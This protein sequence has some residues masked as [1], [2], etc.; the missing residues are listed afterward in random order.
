M[1]A[2]E[3]LELLERERYGDLAALEREAFTPRGRPPRPRKPVR[4]PF[5]APPPISREQGLANRRRLLEALVGT[6]YEPDPRPAAS[7]APPSRRTA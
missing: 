5:T 3:L 6:P 2:A 7:P 4:R 1:S